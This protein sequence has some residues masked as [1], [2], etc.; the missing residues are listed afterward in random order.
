MKKSFLSLFGI[1]LINIGLIGIVVVAYV[2]Y[3]NTKDLPDYK[4]L[5][6]YEPPIVTRF[7]TSDGRLLEEYALERR[8]F[9][10]IKAIP[11]QLINAF[12]AAEDKNFYSHLGID[13]TSI[14]RAVFQ[15]IINAS[16]SKSTLV[17][18]STI[19]QQVVKNF[20]LT[21]ERSLSRKIKEA[22]LSFR[23]SKAFSKDKIL[24]LY[25]NQIFLGNG[26]YGVASA[27]QNYF[28][29]SINELSI[30]ESAFLAALPK[31]PST[32]NPKIRYKRA[33]SRRNWVLERMYEEDFITREQAISAMR[34]PIKLHRRSGVNTVESG[35]FAEAVR[36]KVSEMYGEEKLYC[37]GLMVSTTLDPKMQLIANKALRYGL[38]KYDRKRGYRG[39]VKKLNNL[40]NWRDELKEIEI[41]PSIGKWQYAV[42]LEI[43]KD[44]IYIGTQKSKG[45]ILKDEFKWATKYRKKINEYLSVGDVIVISTKEKDNKIIY[46]LE[47][48]P[49]VNGS[50]VAMD[51]HTGR[52]L[53][54]VGGYDYKGSKFNRALQAN[55]QP[56]SSYK[57]FVYLAALEQ[58]FTPSTIIEDGPIEIFQG[59]GLPIWR[60]KNYSGDFLGP[61]TL[62]RGL[63]L[64]RNTMTVNLAQMLGIKKIVEITKRFGINDNP[65]PLYS[66]VLG[67]METTLLKMVTAYSMFVNGGKKIEPTLIEKIQNRYG[68][69]IFKHDKRTCIRCKI[70]DNNPIISISEADM[71]IIVDNRERVTDPRS[72]FQI[73]SILQGVVEHTRSSRQVRNLGKILGGK[74]GTTNNNFDSWFIGFSPDLVV[75]VY[76]GFDEPKSLGRNETGA[77]VAQPIFVE[78]MREALKNKP[79]IPFRTPSGIKHV[80]VNFKTGLPSSENEGIIYEVFKVGTEPK[81]LDFHIEEALGSGSYYP[82]IKNKNPAEVKKQLDWILTPYLLRNKNNNSSSSNDDTSGLY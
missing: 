2:I 81:E 36:Q 70:T 53:S 42:V 28:N 72:A 25:L 75:G 66:M 30:E 44:K 67:S 56:G 18:G 24:E 12:V 19:T 43:N 52:I 55:R 48:I 31:A 9:V 16:Q 13:I 41:D 58:G 14:M 62:R 11:R 40:D 38:E 76:V 15:N 20:L 59:S 21:N 5:A 8:S 17:G 45:Y 51:P 79:N 82:A 73:V 3:S 69:I 26:S 1:L 68:N 6:K 64:S 77:T 4:Q 37:G 46:S 60:P 23:V 80:K 54:M 29:K 78:F 10:P 32:Y 47:Q 7:Y 35:F 65:K 61:T 34:K 57:P 27:A 33:I 71:P 39:A 63:E 49:K 50:I 74:T 22:I